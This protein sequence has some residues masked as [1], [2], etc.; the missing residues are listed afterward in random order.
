MPL[1]DFILNNFKWK[2]SALFLAMLVWFLIQLAM[3]EGFH[4]GDAPLEDFR[5]YTF[6]RQ[7]IRVM[8]NPGERS[9]Y[10]LTPSNVDV[11]IRSTKGALNRLTENDI[12][13]FVTLTDAPEG[14]AETKEVFVYVPDNV[15]VYDIQVSPAAVKVEKVAAPQGE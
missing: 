2:L 8:A 11:V 4:L 7:P 1:R 13:V 10:R 9:P 5:T 6:F 12:K 14:V 15:E 3:S